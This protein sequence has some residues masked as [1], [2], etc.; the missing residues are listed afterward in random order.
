MKIKVGVFNY[1]LLEVED[2]VNEDDTK[3]DGEICPDKEVI[4][5][6]KDIPK[7]AKIVTF[8][9]EIVHSLD[10]QYRM[11]LDEDNIDRLAHGLTQVILENKNYIKGML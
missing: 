3:L 10:V 1:D 6:E 9:H 7:T 11:S 4:R 2:L 8:W 5:I